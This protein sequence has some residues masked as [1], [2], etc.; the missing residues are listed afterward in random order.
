MDHGFNNRLDRTDRIQFLFGITDVLF[1]SPFRD[2]KDGRC[3]NVRFSLGNPAQHLAFPGRE[4]RTFG[5][6]LQ[7]GFKLQPQN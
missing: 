6:L 1:D 3:L 5:D 4:C 7:L 2:S